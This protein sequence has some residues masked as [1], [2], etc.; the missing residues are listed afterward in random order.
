MVE[1]AEE[2][3]SGELESTRQEEAGQLR[4]ATILHPRFSRH[5]SEFAIKKEGRAA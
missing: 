5:P 3:S 4:L 2:C 1:P